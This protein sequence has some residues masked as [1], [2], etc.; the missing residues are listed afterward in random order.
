[1]SEPLWSQED[2]DAMRAAI[3]DADKES[4][5]C[6]TQQF[7]ALLAGALLMLAFTVCLV[8]AQMYSA[9]EV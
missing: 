9:F 8:L 5:R 4:R 3:A 7:W 1:M 2:T 6:Q